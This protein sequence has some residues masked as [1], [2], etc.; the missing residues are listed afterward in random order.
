MF[1]DFMLIFTFGQTFCIEQNIMESEFRIVC[2]SR[3]DTIT[4]LVNIYH[5]LKASILHLSSCSDCHFLLYTLVVAKFFSLFGAWSLL[6]RPMF[7]NLPGPPNALLALSTF[8]LNKWL[9][10]DLK[11]I[12]FCFFLRKLIHFCI[13][14]IPNDFPSKRSKTLFLTLNNWI[15]NKEEN[16]NK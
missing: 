13:W 11:H 16:Q 1:L 9:P 4:M 2:E 14:T 7:H 3:S 15:R 8:L 12:S 5:P 6:D 10:S